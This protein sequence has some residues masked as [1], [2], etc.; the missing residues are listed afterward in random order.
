VIEA[1]EQEKLPGRGSSL[2]LLVVVTAAS[3]FFWDLPWAQLVLGPVATFVTAV[4]E[5][6]HALACLATGG[7][8]SG[9][10]IVSDNSGHGGLTMCHGGN[11]FIY[12]QAGYLGTALFGCFLI[13]IGRHPRLSKAALVLTGLAVGA[14]SVTLMTGAIFN[15]WRIWQGLASLSWGLIIAAALVFAGLKLRPDLANLLILVLAVETALNSL[16][17][18]VLL[19]KISLGFYP[20]A[21]FSDATNMQQM[22]G[23][24]AA[25]WSLAWA[26]ASIAMLG[27]TL[28]HCYGPRRARPV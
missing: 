18:V 2:A 8:V 12:T 19:V 25:V 1:I 24:P 17:D 20:Y 6:G 22:T 13:F 26:G 15:E 4:H 9:L 16:T 10:T 23:I 28:W 5:M 27:A 11:P 3:V 14:A 21:S 7:S